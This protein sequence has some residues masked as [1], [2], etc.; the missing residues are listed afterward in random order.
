[1]EGIFI[2]TTVRPM[3]SSVKKLKSRPLGTM[4]F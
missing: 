3:F 4:K 1:M 2:E